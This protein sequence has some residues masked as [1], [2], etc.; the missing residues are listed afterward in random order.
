MRSDMHPLLVL[1]TMEKSRE[2][3]LGEEIS[4]TLLEQNVAQLAGSG[5]WMPSGLRASKEQNG[6]GSKI[7]DEAPMWVS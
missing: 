6:A 5:R 3:I 7:G 1:E 2:G 4:E